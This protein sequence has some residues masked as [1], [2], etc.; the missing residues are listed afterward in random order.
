[1]TVCDFDEIFIEDFNSKNEKNWKI[2]SLVHDMVKGHLKKKYDAIYSLDVLEH[3]KKSNEKNF[4]LN[5]LKS[6]KNNGV[7]ICGMP[8]IESQKYAS[9]ASKEGHVNC[10]TGDELKKLMNK[11]FENTFKYN[12]Y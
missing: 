3:I 1:L 12:F 9:K 6:L 8:S 5:C 7:F 4:L 2:K 11:Y 10:K